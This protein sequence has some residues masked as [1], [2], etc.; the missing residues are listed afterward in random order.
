MSNA[1]VEMSSSKGAQVCDHLWYGKEHVAQF[2]RLHLPVV[3]LRLDRVVREH[4]GLFGNKQGLS[5]SAGSREVL[6]GRELVCVPL[7]VAHRCIVER[8]VTANVVQC[9]TFLYLKA[10]LPISMTSPRSQARLDELRGSVI[11]S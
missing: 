9:V 1:A 6:A 8:R 7:P 10:A 11:G 5:E 3:Q 4:T 2:G